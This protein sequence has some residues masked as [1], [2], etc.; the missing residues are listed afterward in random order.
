LNITVNPEEKR[1]IIGDTFM[2]VAQLEIQKLNLIPDQVYLGTKTSLPSSLFLP[3][4]SLS[5]PSP[6]SVVVAYTKSG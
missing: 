6:S 2:K 3:P 4:L 5:S 1:K